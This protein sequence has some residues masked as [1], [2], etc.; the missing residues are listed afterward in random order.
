MSERLNA[1][2]DHYSPRLQHFSIFES[3]LIS[4]LGGFNKY[5]IASV[6]RH[7]CLLMEPVAILYEIPY[8]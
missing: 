1:G 6:G 3:E 4:F 2:S 7:S 8:G 5:Y